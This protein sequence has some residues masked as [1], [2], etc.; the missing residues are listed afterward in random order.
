MYQSLLKHGFHEP[1]NMLTSVLSRDIFDAVPSPLRQASTLKVR[2]QGGYPW[3][4]ISIAD[5]R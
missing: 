5:M 3:L 4:P 2:C 1:L